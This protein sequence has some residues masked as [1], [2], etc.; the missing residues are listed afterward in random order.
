MAEFVELRGGLIVRLDAVQLALELEQGGHTLR[1]ADDR[2]VVS[3]GGDLAPEQ[4]EHI[5]TVKD[6]LIAIA[7]Y[8]PD[9]ARVAPDFKQRQL[10]EDA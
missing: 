2:L 10:G 9:A 6:H 1:V 7:T 5:R 4:R 8:Q 3:R